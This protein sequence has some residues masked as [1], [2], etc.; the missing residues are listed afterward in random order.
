MA[1]R[2]AAYEAHGAEKVNAELQEFDNLFGK[3]SMVQQL[4]L[5]HEAPVFE[6]M[7]IMERFRFEKQYGNSPADIKKN[8]RAEF[9]KEMRETIRQEESD[10]LMGRLDKKKAHPSV[11]SSRG[12]NGV[13]KDAKPKGNGPTPLKE[14]FK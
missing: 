7:R 13:G 12:S 5:D 1:S 4:V 6:A 10:K 3:N 11:T 14:I 2:A 9:E 8:I